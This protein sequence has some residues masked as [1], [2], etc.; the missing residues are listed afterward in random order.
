MGAQ[1]WNDST[2]S[3]DLLGQGVM[4]IMEFFENRAVKRSVFPSLPLSF[5]SP[6]SFP[7]HPS[8]PCVAVAFERARWSLLGCGGRCSSQGVVPA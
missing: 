4:S 7:L 1:V 8:R 2:F 6:S 5:L 3:D